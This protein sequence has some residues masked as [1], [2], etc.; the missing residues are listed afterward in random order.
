[1]NCF[2]KV[3]KFKFNVNANVMDSEHQFRSCFSSIKPVDHGAN[4][5]GSR[6]VF[7]ICCFVFL[8]KLKISLNM[9]MLSEIL[10][11]KS[12]TIIFSVYTEY[13]YGPGK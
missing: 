12:L 1:M 5:I 7:Q 13:A 6:V 4:L 11:A 8:T 10:I 2:N 9:I 3:N